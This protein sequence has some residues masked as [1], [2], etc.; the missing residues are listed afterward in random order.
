[1]VGCF[2]MG[3][4]K[5]SFLK[6]PLNSQEHLN[7]LRSRNLSILNENQALTIL[8]NISYYRLSG[9]F[10][11]FYIQNT[12][13]FIDGS[14]FDQIL[15]LYNFDRELRLIVL[16]AIERIEVALRTIIS[17]YMSI[18]YGINWYL[19]DEVFSDRWIQPNHRSVS[20]KEKFMQDLNSI[21]FSKRAYLPI[22]HFYKNYD[23]PDYPPS[24]MIIEYLSF[25]SLIQ[26][27]RYLR[28]VKDKKIIADKFKLS[29]TEFETFLEPIRIL[30]NISAHHERM[31]NKWFVY[32][33]KKV[34]FWP[35]LNKH[36]SHRFYEQILILL[37]LISNDIEGIEWMNKIPTLFR[38][39]NKVNFTHMGFDQDWENDF[40]WK[41]K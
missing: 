38:Q 11:P 27:W 39:Y 24:W 6:N 3:T 20:A 12:E 21:C 34:S 19:N 35:A 10:I 2:F 5:N 4:N 40:I 32:T 8:N 14:T 31:W 37:T 30:R 25:G 15:Y 28:R 1:M 23:R 41:M 36:S 13:Q 9:Y 16:D 18:T 7:L 22:Q 26:L 29:P 17:N 33:P